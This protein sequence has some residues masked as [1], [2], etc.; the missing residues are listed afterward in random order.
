MKKIYVKYK[1]LVNGL[2]TTTPY[3]IDGFTLKSSTFD[4]NMFSDKYDEN[5]DGIDF[6]L[7]FYLESCFTDFEKLSYNYFESDNYEEIEVSNKVIINSKT[8]TRLL[9]SKMEIYNKINDLERKIRLILNIP[10]IF[11]I[12]CI[13]FYD[14]DKKFL[15]AVQGNRQLSFWNRLTYKI[16]P[17]EFTNNSRYGMDFNAMKST[18]NNQFNRALEFYNDS[19][20]SEKISSRYILIFS[21]LEAIFNLDTEDVT[22]KISRYSAKLLAEENEVEYK[23]VY[24]DIKKLYKKRC[25]YIHG[26]KTNNILDE[27]EKLLRFY[28]RKI[29]LAYWMI[30]LYTKKTAK[31]ILEYL[32]SDEKLDLQVRLFISALNSHNFTEQQH[33]IVDIVE[34]EIGQEIPE[35]TKQTIYSKCNDER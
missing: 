25:D 20:E 15:T 11:Q 10:L 31:Q 30:I 23:Q 19:F 9:Q 6:N 26:S 17:E 34:K 1:I 29:I 32:N 24:S 21:A 27:D 7:N 13:E 22:K 33:R 5:K 16:N 4:K 12:V 35:E 8:V 3:T 2:H 28:V 14:K 18:D